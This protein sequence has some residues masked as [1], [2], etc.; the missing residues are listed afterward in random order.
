MKLLMKN[1][2]YKNKVTIQM[3]GREQSSSNL[4]YKTLINTTSDC[5][6]HF[7]LSNNIVNVHICNL[8][9]F[10]CIQQKHFTVK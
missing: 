3:K 7:K 1:T 2:H 4:K 6:R 10:K 9:P 5:R 8:F